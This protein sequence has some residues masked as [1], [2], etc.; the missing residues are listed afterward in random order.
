VD[1]KQK[2]L[3][4]VTVIAWHTD[5]HVCQEKV[6]FLLENGP[7]FCCQMISFQQAGCDS[8]WF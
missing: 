2:R 8:A 6:T 4:H 1:A 5:R 7:V 3:L